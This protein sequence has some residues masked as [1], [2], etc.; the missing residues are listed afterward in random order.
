LDLLWQ[1]SD[2]KEAESFFNEWCEQAIATK[3]E[4]ILKFAAL[5]KSHRTGILNWFN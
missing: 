4:P 2:P 1:E 3:V 5:L